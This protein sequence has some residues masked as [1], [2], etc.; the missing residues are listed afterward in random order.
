LSRD[1]APDQAGKCSEEIIRAGDGDR[2]YPSFCLVDFMR[3]PTISAFD[4]NC[5]KSKHVSRAY[6]VDVEIFRLLHFWRIAY[7]LLKGKG[8][9][10]R[11]HWERTLVVAT[12]AIAIVV[13]LWGIK[14]LLAA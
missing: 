7:G 11:A 13:C 1:A 8:E 6:V 14:I 4:S 10:M 5:P 2:T 12:L 9:S 3:T